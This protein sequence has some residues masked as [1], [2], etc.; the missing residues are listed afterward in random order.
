MSALS[1]LLKS[2]PISARRAAEIAAEQNLHLPYGTIAAYW[3]GKHGRPSQSTL[4]RLATVLNIPLKQLQQ[5]A[6]NATAPLGM[7]E[8]P[9]E[10]ALLDQ[11]QRDVLGELI[12]SI[13]ATRGA[14]HGTD[15]DSP[16]A[17]PRASSEETENKEEEVTRKGLTLIPGDQAN[18]LEDAPPALDDE[19]VAARETPLGYRKGQ[20]VDE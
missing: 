14:T 13:V 9:E 16:T 12:K 19:D 20:P 5:A 8:P 4:T 7:W 17:T 2:Q 6:W 18:D 3:S 11:R 10:A 15:T 1:D